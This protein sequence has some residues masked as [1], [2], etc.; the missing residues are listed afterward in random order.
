VFIV[1][2]SGSHAVQERMSLVKG[3]VNGLLQAG[4]GRH[5]EI[6]VIA[7]RGGAGTVLVGPTPVLADVERALEYMP[8]LP[9]SWMLTT[10]VPAGSASRSVYRGRYPSFVIFVMSG[11]RRF[12][13]PSAGGPVMIRIGLP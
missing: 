8:T 10:E 3:A 9:W 4:H 6:V 11:Q 5:D 2:S 13:P 7:C 12:V 1:D